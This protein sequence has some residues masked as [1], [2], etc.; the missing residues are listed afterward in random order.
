MITTET[1]M[2]VYLGAE[3]YAVLARSRDIVVV[4]KGQ[5]RRTAREEK[6]VK[7]G[8]TASVV[9]ELLLFVP[10]SATLVLLISPLLLTRMSWSAESPRMQTAAYSLLGIVS[11]GFPFAAIR[12]VI[13]RMAANTLAQFA[14]IAHKGTK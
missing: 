5:A 13:T 7:S 1:W 2:M 11:Y 14:S 10:V 4:V 6:E 9:L 8:L 12:T 3:L